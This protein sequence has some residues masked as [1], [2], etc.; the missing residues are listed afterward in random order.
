MIKHIKNRW[1]S[2][3]T[4][5]LDGD[6]SHEFGSILNAVLGEL[7]DEIIEGLEEG[8]DAGA[9]IIM[10]A[11]SAASPVK[12]NKLSKSWIV[13]KYPKL[14]RIQNTIMVKGQKGDNINLAGL[15]EYSTVHGN[16]FIEQTVNDNIEKAAEVA[17]QKIMKLNVEE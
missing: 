4:I 1:Q 6:S 10:D 3:R 9:Q 11:L 7:N 8:L 2:P 15:L 12:T 13:K 17:A 5:R 16:P 14:R